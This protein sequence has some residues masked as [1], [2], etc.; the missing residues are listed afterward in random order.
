MKK[1][2]LASTA[3]VG[4]AGAAAAD[5]AVSG[6]A[7]MGI[8]GGSAT[9]TQ[10]SQNVDVNFSMSGETDGGLAFG[11]SVD[12]D[13]SAGI[14]GSELD[15][16]GVAVFIS[17]DFG[18]LTM[19]DT[20]GALD[21]ALQEANIGHPGSIN[22]AETGH[23]GWNGSY[24]DGNGAGDGQILR[25]DN[26]FGDF[27]VAVSLE[28]D[29]IGG[30]S[31]NDIGYAIGAK[32]SVA[33]AGGSLGIGVGYQQAV[34]TTNVPSATGISLAYTGDNGFSGVIVYTDMD[35]MT[36]DSHLGLGVAYTSGALTVAANYGEYS[37]AAGGT[38]DG[39]GLNVGYDLGGGA[40]IKAAYGDS[41]T[42]TNSWS[43]GIAM[44]F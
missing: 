20:D 16:G 21:W 23:S 31:T 15:D 2:L 18:T 30:T 5:V 34:G 42:G 27:S 33:M 13:E 32:Y 19:G 28:Q 4:F 11:V 17:G 36:N 14:A 6:S 44:S 9:D 29:L 24:L 3:L 22:D 8:V 37:V 25:Y 7:E 41:S 40:S 26:T 39:Y 35:N 10:F 43:L 38:V 1:I 12:L